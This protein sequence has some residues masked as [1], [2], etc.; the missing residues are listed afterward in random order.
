M[1]QKLRD[2][3]KRTS[4][5]LA[6]AAIISVGAG[7]IASRG[8]TAPTPRSEI[9]KPI[10]PDFDKHINELGLIMV[11]T[12]EE[13]YHLARNRDGWV[14][15]E[16]GNYPVSEERIVELAQTPAS[17]KYAEAMTRDHRKFD[18]IGLG[19][20]LDGGTGALLEIGDGR[21]NAF[22]NAIVGYRSG[23]WYVR[24][25]DDLQAWATEGGDFPPLQRASRWLNLEAAKIPRAQIAQVTVRPVVGETYTLSPQGT[26]DG[27]FSITEPTYDL[28]VLVPFS[29]S[30]IGNALADY[31]P[32]DVVPA[33]ELRD[34][35]L[36]GTH[37]T[38]T[39][40]GILIEATA[41]RSGGRG[42]IIFRASTALSASSE[43]V[44][45]AASI[46]RT[47]S[48]W[49]YAVTESDWEAFSTPLALLA[50]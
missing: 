42:W 33:N 36:N 38:L 48:S 9:G 20:P 10:A 22:F 24:Q 37:T 26:D 17:M 7:L 18:R 16:K 21:G 50:Q 39:H 2:K 6:G 41:L 31:A 32:V 13:S 23:R 3:R 35:T 11:T 25:P 45:K 34:A 27:A 19:D 43:A 29:L 14:L 28:Q 12:S 4:L 30:V 40:D 47:V 8:P 5:M 15:T 44:A 46:N 1:S 49:A